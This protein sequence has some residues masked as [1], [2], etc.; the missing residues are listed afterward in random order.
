MTVRFRVRMAPALVRA[1]V[2]VDGAD[3]VTFT[4]DF[5]RGW[6]FPWA[7]SASGPVNMIPVT[8]LNS[9]RFVFISLY[10]GSE[11]WT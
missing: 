6:S 1:V 10:F 5:A 3:L 2:I 4:C 8:K 9:M 7:A 11:D